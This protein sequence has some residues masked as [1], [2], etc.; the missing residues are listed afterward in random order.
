[1]I[2]SLA[3]KEGYCFATN[4][5]LA[6]K[7]DVNPKTISSWISDLSKRNFIIVEVIR[8]G[9]IYRYTKINIMKNRVVKMLINHF[10]Y[11]ILDINYNTAYFI[12]KYSFPPRNATSTSS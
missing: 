2:I 4:K 9:L 12:F 11:S 5:Y 1:M 6:K 7:L 10:Y 8:N 3:C